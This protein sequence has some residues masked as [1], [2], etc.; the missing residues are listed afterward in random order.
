MININFNDFYKILEKINVQASSTIAS[1]LK[2]QTIKDLLNQNNSNYNF[3]ERISKEDYFYWFEH[4]DV[5]Y[6]QPITIIS[7]HLDTVFD[8]TYE[9]ICPQA[10]D[11]D[12]N[13]EI[14]G[15]FDNSINNAILIYMALNNLLDSNTILVF[16][17]KEEIG[18]HGAYKLGDILCKF[19]NKYKFELEKIITMDVTTPIRSTDKY[20]S[21]D[22]HSGITFENFNDEAMSFFSENEFFNID[23]RRFIGKSLPDESYAYM[24]FNHKGMKPFKNTIIFSLCTIVYPDPDIVY[25][26][27][28]MHSEQGCR[29]KWKTI[30]EAI[31]FL[32]LNCF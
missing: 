21:I 23:N 9:R 29:I 31:K 18:L 26:K 14:I 2:A 11:G 15:T 12:E 30:I 13:K 24:K 7:S 25:K 4:K 1:L 3:N 17:D 28:Y 22:V 27:Y 19:P 20:T 5:D 10:I 32:N 16:T 6:S 8:I